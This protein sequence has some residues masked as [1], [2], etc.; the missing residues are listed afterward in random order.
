M[1]R[2]AHDA[3][4]AC[5]EE[6]FDAGSFTWDV[7]GDFPGIVEWRAEAARLGLMAIA[8]CA[9]TISRTVTGAPLKVLDGVTS[10]TFD[11]VVVH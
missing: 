1:I 9:W 5:S 7:V 2:Q 4:M 11:P 3:L 8:G 10:R 6:A